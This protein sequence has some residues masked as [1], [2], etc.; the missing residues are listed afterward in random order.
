MSPNKSTEPSETRGQSRETSEILESQPPE[1]VSGLK[2]FQE[3]V[4]NNFG[5]RFD[6]EEFSWQD[7]VGGPRGIIESIG[8]T[9]V[10]VVAYVAGL[11]VWKSGAVALGLAVGL[12]IARLFSKQTI[13]QATAG[14]FGVII[15]VVWAMWS[16]KGENYFL[17]GLILNAAY[18]LALGISVVVRYPLIGLVVGW[19]RGQGVK[20][21]KD[22]RLRRDRKAYYVVTVLWMI[23]FAAR[24]LVKLPLYLAGNV[25]ILGTIHLLMG[26][27]LFALF[28]YFSWLLLR[29]TRGSFLDS[30]LPE[31]AD[32]ATGTG[33]AVSLGDLDANS[34]HEDIA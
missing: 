31:P 23:L 30:G 11:D 5:G 33:S 19:F 24:L 16:G 8:P 26:V 3:T 22:P 9:L 4:G 18:F 10:F 27:P 7:A 25:P 29:R 13:T 2:E 6:S 21:R 14:F 32:H 28:L 1:L 17:Y 20:W 15:G 12:I 34:P